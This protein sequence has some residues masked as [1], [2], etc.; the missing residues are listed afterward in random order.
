MLEMS[1]ISPQ[2]WNWQRAEAQ[3]IVR[4][5]VAVIALQESARVGALP[6]PDP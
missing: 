3:G 1:S 4:L 2:L 5:V 6:Y